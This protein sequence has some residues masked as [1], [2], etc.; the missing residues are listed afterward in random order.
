MQL[1]PVAEHRREARVELGAQRDRCPSR[2]P[3]AAS[4]E[5]VVQD[6]MDVA[7]LELE[8]RRRAE[9]AQLLDQ[10]VEPVDLADDDVGAAD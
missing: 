9:V 5:D 2:A 8:R 10:A 4:V 6:A 7:R 3:G 1:R